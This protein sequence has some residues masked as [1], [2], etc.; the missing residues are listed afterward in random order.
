MDDLILSSSQ[1][2]L[3][4]FYKIFSKKLLKKY[5]PLNEYDM[6]INIENLPSIYINGQNNHCIMH[7]AISLRNYTN[8]ELFISLIQIDLD[9]N[10]Y[11]FLSIDKILLK[12][13]KKK[14]G[15]QLLIEIPLNYYQVRKIQGMIS[16]GS[17][18]LYSNFNLRIFT[19]NIFGDTSFHR[20]LNGSFEVKNIPL[21]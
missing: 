2:I 13:F 15:M 8:Y 21:E 4:W 18:V 16:S 14:E 12:N 7:F 17:N 10:N 6:Q 1:K 9:I 11:R 3:F 20:L 5:F 19:K